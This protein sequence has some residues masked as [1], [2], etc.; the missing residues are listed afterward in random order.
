MQAPVSRLTGLQT[1]TVLKWEWKSKRKHKHYRST[2][3]CDIAC[4]SSGQQEGLHR[5][6]PNSVN[7]GI[8]L[9]V[10]RSRAST[11]SE[12]SLSKL[13][14]LC[15]RRCFEGKCSPGS[16]TDLAH[17]PLPEV[18]EDLISKEAGNDLYKPS[19][20]M[21]LGFGDDGE[22]EELEGAVICDLRFSL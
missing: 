12:R 11:I 3:E 15:E 17:T 18:V 8:D 22:E 10:L 16:Q 19:E 7:P 21:S 14:G 13:L 2:I 20:S 1:D 9:R 6:K 5:N 4:T